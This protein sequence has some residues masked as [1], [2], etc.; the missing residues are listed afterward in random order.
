MKSTSV[1]GLVMAVVAAGVLATLPIARADTD[2]I[3]TQCQAD[4]QAAGIQDPSELQAY[5]EE[6]MKAA[7]G[8]T[9]GESTDAAPS[10]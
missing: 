9:E 6:C 1:R 10:S 2:E 7:S 3:R 8:E 5:I 4:A